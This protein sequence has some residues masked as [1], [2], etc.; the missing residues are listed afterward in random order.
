LNLSPLKLGMTVKTLADN[1]LHVLRTKDG[2]TIA[3]S[4]FTSGGLNQLAMNGIIHSIDNVIYPYVSDETAT[5]PRPKS[6]RFA[7][8][9]FCTFKKVYTSC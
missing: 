4:L 9:K 3:G 8:F 6:L 1:T 7:I 5:T 2:L